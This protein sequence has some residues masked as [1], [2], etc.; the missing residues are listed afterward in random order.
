[1]LQKP[2]RPIRRESRYAD[3]R[4]VQLEHDL[5]TRL[6]AE[7]D[8]SHRSISAVAREAIQ[9]GLPLVRRARKNRERQ[10]ARFVAR[11]GES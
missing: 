11:D 1:M 7:A 8:R 3:P 2:K 9:R 4:G 5:D 10:A 6:V